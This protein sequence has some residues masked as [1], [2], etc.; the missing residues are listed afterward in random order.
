MQSHA[1]HKLS[2]LAVG[3]ILRGCDAKLATHRHHPIRRPPLERIKEVRVQIAKLEVLL[4][5]VAVD[6]R[7]RKGLAPCTSLLSPHGA[8]LVIVM[9]IR[10]VKVTNTKQPLAGLPRCVG[11]LEG[12]QVRGG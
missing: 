9:P 6:A 2:A 12:Y 5:V 4:L 8:H 7:A 10:A 1:R 11:A 3:C